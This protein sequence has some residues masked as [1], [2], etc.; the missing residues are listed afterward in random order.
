MVKNIISNKDGFAVIAN[1][2]IPLRTN[3]LPNT[4]DV[5]APHYI[6]TG[7]YAGYGYISYL[8]DSGNTSPVFNQNN[9]DFGYWSVAV[10]H[11]DTGLMY[12]L[13]L[14]Y[15]DSR[16]AGIIVVSSLDI[17]DIRSG[18]FNPRYTTLLR[19]S[20]KT[21]P[22]TLGPYNRLSAV[23]LSGGRICVFGNLEILIINIT[24]NAVV[25]V[26][27]PSTAVSYHYNAYTGGLLIYTSQY[28]YCNVNDPTPAFVAVN[29]VPSD[30]RWSPTQYGFEYIAGNATV[31]TGADFWYAKPKL[32]TIADGG[33]VT[34]K[35]LDV[36]LVDRGYQ[37]S[38]GVPYRV[39]IA[40]G[41]ARSTSTGGFYGTWFSKF[42]CYS[43][44]CYYRY[45]ATGYATIYGNFTQ[46]SWFL[47][48]D[49][50]PSGT[51]FDDRTKYLAA[52]PGSGSNPPLGI[53]STYVYGYV[54][55]KDTNGPNTILS[56]LSS[57]YNVKNEAQGWYVI[58]SSSQETWSC[59]EIPR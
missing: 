8:D 32:Y 5:I 30:V 39:T 7:Y 22:P 10:R 52:H 48:A 40:Y 56:D 38:G 51:M 31:G 44:Q 50:T 14:A 41:N 23:P 28:Y 25:R 9:G 3:V 43:E 29:G 11:P 37:M 36:S 24:M 59:A 33:A 53:T 16:Y 13:S 35:I 15:P 2:D 49:T 19:V 45:E 42:D 47:D 12:I 21:P 6:I 27:P 26:T 20:F 57:I 58:S 17:D 4:Q 1:T 55:T 46:S 54:C 18:K 34:E